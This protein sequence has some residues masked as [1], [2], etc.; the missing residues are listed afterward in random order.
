M[1][2]ALGEWAAMVTQ[3]QNEAVGTVLRVMSE[4]DL[5]EGPEGR[6]GENDP[7]FRTGAFC[8]GAQLASRPLV[9]EYIA[10]EP[11]ELQTIFDRTFRLSFHFSAGVPLIQSMYQARIAR[12][13]REKYGEQEL[14]E[15]VDK[16]VLNPAMTSP[17]VNHINGRAMKRAVKRAPAIWKFYMDVLKSNDELGELRPVDK[18]RHEQILLLETFGNE[19]MYP[20]GLPYFLLRRECIYLEGGRP[21]KLD[22]NKKYRSDV[23][24]Y[25]ISG[26]SLRNPEFNLIFSELGVVLKALLKLTTTELPDFYLIT[27][28]KDNL[29]KLLGLAGLEALAQNP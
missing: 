12:L 14:T 24:D 17:P 18:M 3:Q 7:T 11:I 5:G 15:A 27:E 4:L 29:T 25:A 26:K 6:P 10:S 9:D 21:N 8:Y 20:L 19:D 28:T 16:A 22:A 2:T 1:T 13:L 23:I